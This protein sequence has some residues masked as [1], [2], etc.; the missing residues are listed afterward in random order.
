M[1]NMKAN[2]RASAFSPT[3]QPG[4]LDAWT[5]GRLLY[6]L[7]TEFCGYQA[8]YAMG[9]RHRQQRSRNQ[10]SDLKFFSSFQAPQTTRPHGAPGSA[11]P[12]NTTLLGVFAGS[13]RVPPTHHQIPKE[14]TSTCL[15]VLLVNV[16]QQFYGLVAN[17]LF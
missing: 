9:C 11:P 8:C 14:F 5:P 17:G 10:R 4:R 3:A 13:W 7:L 16:N 1:E 6:F 2:A 12:T 15:V